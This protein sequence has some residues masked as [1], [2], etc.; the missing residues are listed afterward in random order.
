MATTWIVRP[1]LGIALF[2][3]VVAGC[4]G[5]SEPKKKEKDPKAEKPGKTDTTP[6]A[7]VGMPAGADDAAKAFLA[8][9]TADPSKLTANFKKVLAPTATDPGKADWEAEQFLAKSVVGKAGTLKSSYALAP[10][11]VIAATP[12]AFVKLVKEPG[13]WLVDWVH[14]GPPG[15][16]TWPVDATGSAFATAAFLDTAITQQHLLVEAVLSP[17]LKAKLAPPADDV[18][19]DRGYNQ[20]ILRLKLSS[21]RGSVTGYTME[22]VN[23]GEATGKLS[24]GRAFTIKLVKSSKPGEWLVEDFQAQ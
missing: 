3:I 22:K 20:G 15:D 16:R 11:T 5:S 2:A 21:F 24:D 12:W 10:D 13:G 8:S 6:P 18:D 7:P 23:V 9:T 14:V 19:R 1:A 17:A 4:G